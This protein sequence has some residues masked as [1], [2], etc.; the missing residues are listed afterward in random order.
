ML[1]CG[2]PDKMGYVAYRCLHCGQGAH[3]G[4]M[5]GKSSLCLRCA[6]AYVDNSNRANT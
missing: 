1:A 5:R 6:K 2:N 3:R 4:S